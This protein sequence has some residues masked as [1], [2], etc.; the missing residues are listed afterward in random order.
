MVQCGGECSASA[1]IHTHTHTHPH[2]NTPTPPH[3][4][5]PTPPH[6]LRY[7]QTV[8][9]TK[10]GLGSALWDGAIL[11]ADFLQQRRTQRLATVRGRRVVEVGCG[12]GLVSTVL[13]LLEA[14]EVVATDGDTALL[15]LT[16]KNIVRNAVAAG[17]RLLGEGGGTPTDEAEVTDGA[18][19]A[20]NTANAA[21][22]TTA[23]ATV[24]ATATSGG[25][26]VKTGDRAGA[27]EGGGGVRVSVNT[28]MWGDEAGARALGDPFDLVVAADVIF[29]RDE[30]QK[31]RND[32]NTSEPLHAANDAF[33][34]LVATLDHL[35]RPGSL[36][37]IAYKQR[38]TRESRF[39]DLMRPIFGEPRKVKR[40]HMHEDFRNSRM[41]INHWT[42]PEKAAKA[43]GA[44]GGAGG[45]GGAVEA[46]AKKKNGASLQPPPPAM[47]D[48]AVEEEEDDEEAEAEA[49]RNEL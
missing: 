18:T 24:T 30:R 43:V 11:L 39:F 28:L 49:P 33:D 14:G 31:P 36:V 2:H 12:L 15:P 5:T 7:K 6:I 4:H 22:T 17:V 3:T 32:T 13:A 9:G 29:E 38:Y 16:R 40:R 23:T 10:V 35:S 41:W 25:D 42:K 37:V 19:A 45:T 46:N 34:K 44:T 47:Q 8:E 26:A 1:L 21:S 20:A 48:S 27:G